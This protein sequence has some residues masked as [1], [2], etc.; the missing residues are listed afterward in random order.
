MPLTICE[1]TRLQAPILHWQEESYEMSRLEGE[2][3]LQHLGCGHGEKN[4]QGRNSR[5]QSKM[6]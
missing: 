3:T 6:P 5:R 4:S 2:N 1:L